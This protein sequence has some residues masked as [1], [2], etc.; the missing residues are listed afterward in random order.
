M[1]RRE[2]LFVLGVFLLESMENSKEWSMQKW[3]SV[4]VVVV[5][6]VTIEG[7][8]LEIVQLVVWVGRPLKWYFVVAVAVL[9]TR[10]EVLL[11]TLFWI[12]L[13]GDLLVGSAAVFWVVVDSEAVSLLVGSA[14]VFWVVVDSKAVSS[15]VGSEAVLWV[16]VDS[17]AA[18]LVVESVAVSKGAD[19]LEPVSLIASVSA[20]EH[21]LFLCVGPIWWTWFYQMQQA[22]PCTVPTDSAILVQLLRSTSWSLV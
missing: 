6:A 16:V 15:L 21:L 2:Q 4:S 12:S 3:R 1:E 14:A 13:P 10:G 19:R 20:Q 8:N 11:E 7:R 9:V 18:S 17:E 5:G 22:L